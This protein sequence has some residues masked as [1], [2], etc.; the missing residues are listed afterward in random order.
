M[1]HAS[2]LQALEIAIFLEALFQR[3]G[4]DFRHYAKASVKRRVIALAE[5]SACASVADLI[6]RVLHDDAFLALALRHLSVPVTEMFRDPSVFKA[7]RETIVP[8]LRSYP[9][10]NIWQAGCASGEEV[11]SLAIVLAEE[12][13]LDRVQIY[14][15][16]INDD[17]L[18]Q[19]EDGIFPIRN[20]EDFTR[21]YQHAGG[22]ACLSDYYVSNNEFLC[23][24]Q[25]LR[26]KIVFAHHNLVSDGV[27]CEVQLILCRNVLIY[28]D[29]SLQ[30]RVL[31]LFYESLTR[32]GFLCLGTRES[33]RHSE[34]EQQFKPVDQPNMIFRKLPELA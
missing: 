34:V 32:G 5:A 3:H 1:K 31:K 21:N 33:L 13:L 17:A 2:D 27:F 15:T 14:A 19:G 28:F 26:E 25:R 30:N 8:L 20:L 7:L 18:H 23:M 4:Y 9:R 12:G 24:S 11:Y 16:D 6:P 10:L 22:K 29:N